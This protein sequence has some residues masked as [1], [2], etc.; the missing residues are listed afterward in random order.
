MPNLDAAVDDAGGGNCP[1]G[2]SGGQLCCYTCG[3]PGCPYGC[4]TPVN[5]KCP[6]F[7]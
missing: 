2:C 7:P 3:V 4:L 6:M 1:G 5:G